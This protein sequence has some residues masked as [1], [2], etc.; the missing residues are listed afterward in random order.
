MKTII[1]FIELARPVEWTKSFGNMLIA[2][3]TAAMIF[4]I[5]L[6]AI[7]FLWG[8]ASIA[9][10]WS[11]LY[12]LNDYTDWRHD[13]LHP[14]KKERAIPSG[15]VKPKHALIFSL[16]LILL[17]LTI[18]VTINILIVL[19]WFAMLINQMLYT[20][21]PFSF[22]KRPVLDLISGSLINPI[23][24]FY[25]GWLLFIPA[26]NAPPIVLL[27]I[28]GIQFGG[29]GLYRLMSKSHEQKLQMSSSV[30]KFGERN[31]RILFYISLIIGAFSYFIS[32]ITIWK[33]SFLALGL[34]IL[35][36]LPVYWRTLKNPQTANMKKMYYIVYLNYLFFLVGFI[37]AFLYF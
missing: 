15:R 6:D 25:Y 13:K 34:I 11:G 37:V 24:R 21:K 1:A 17:S 8:F 19:S 36:F 32:T 3:V 7:I 2:A 29:Y 27:F 31:M 26:F 16:V 5:Q 9:L 10:L 22:K 4:S 18:A 12:T 30:V 23:F 14:V 28:L 20:L 33:I 35:I